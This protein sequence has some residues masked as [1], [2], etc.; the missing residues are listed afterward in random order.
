MN[1]LTLRRLPG[2]IALCLLVGA[3]LALHASDGSP[4]T[5]NLFPAAAGYYEFFVYLPSDAPPEVAYAEQSCSGALIAPQVVLTAAHCTSFNYVEDIGITGYSDQVWVTFDLT[6][7]TND[8]RC[9]LV[10][11]AAEYSEY[12]T[13]DYACDPTRKSDPA[14]TFHAVA[15]A[16]RNAGIAIAHGLTHPD[17]LRPELAPNGRAKR[18]EPNLQNAPD[19]GVLLLERPVVD[20]TPLPIVA[21]GGL[22]LMADLKGTP[23]LSV[24]YGLNWAKL[25][26]EP[27]ASGLGPMSDLGGGNEVKR[28]ARVGPIAVV[29]ETSLI[30]RQSVAKG[31]DTVCFG[32]SGSAMFLERSG[33]VEPTIV[34][35]LSGATN[36]CQGS[37]D[38]YYRLDLPEAHEFL[39]CVI[40]RQ[41][42]VKRA[43]MDCSAE[44]YFGLCDELQGSAD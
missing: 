43:C 10:E 24:G 22:D 16:G 31:D 41:D 20:V 14:P 38:P 9:F 27:P 33:R 6:A 26:G 13:G 30:P 5:G 25:T 12:L 23:A 28:I 34:A 3:P 39:A 44:R 4:D 37:K 1:T 35:V 36:W 40:A 19:V 21:V 2:A 8:F 29:H 7:T 11:T 17:F 15:V 18:V 32:D 42:D